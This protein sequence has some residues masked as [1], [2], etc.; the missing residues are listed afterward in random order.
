LKRKYSVNKLVFIL[1]D[2]WV[3]STLAT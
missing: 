1:V 3:V 2:C